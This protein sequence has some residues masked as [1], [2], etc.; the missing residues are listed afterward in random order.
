LDEYP[1]LLRRILGA[2]SIRA[3]IEQHGYQHLLIVPQKRLYRLPSGPAPGLYPKKF[4]LVVE[5][6]HVIPDEGT[7]SLWKSDFIT[8]ERLHAVYKVI[9]AC[10][11]IDSVYP[12]NI[13]ITFENL[14]AFI[15][16]EHFH[17]WPV[18]YHK[19]SHFLAKKQ[20]VYWTSLYIK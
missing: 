10:G 11:L 6:I 3:S 8:K 2:H 4:I 16:T 9:N 5:E 20:R 12:D 19:L 14:I 18:P 7:Y 1:L 13:P 15:D 17:S